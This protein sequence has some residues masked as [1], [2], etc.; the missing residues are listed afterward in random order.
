[1]MVDFYLSPHGNRIMFVLQSSDDRDHLRELFLDLAHRRVSE[2]SLEDASWAQFST[3]CPPITLK[4]VTQ[5]VS[6]QIQSK[7]TDD[8]ARALCWSR[9]EQG[10]LECAEK[11]DALT[12][13]GHQY[14][15]GGEAEIEVS[16][17]EY[18]TQR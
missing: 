13:P 12:A 16:F 4:F 17:L 1:M 3:D 9:H 11:I 7:R 10:W 2:Y 6:R 14:M 18:P 15:G 8:G 5:E